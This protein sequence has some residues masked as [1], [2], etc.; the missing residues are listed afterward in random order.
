MRQQG[1]QSPV[2]THGFN[3]ETGNANSFFGLFG[4]DFRVFMKRKVKDD[5]RLDDSV[6]AFLELGRETKSSRAWGFCAFTLEK[7]TEE[8]HALYGRALHFVEAV[9]GAL[10]E[11]NTDRAGVDRSWTTRPRR[12][13]LHVVSF[14]REQGRPTPRGDEGQPEG[15]LD[16]GR[17]QAPRTGTQPEVSPAWHESCR[18]HE[19]A[20]TA[21]DGSHAQADQAVL[22]QTG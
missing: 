21:P 3:G 18:A 17:R 14:T 22:H 8:I 4:N 12:S 5:D 9:P 20:W 15:G 16:G 19:R 10:R 13:I 7:T 11:F 6:R 1:G 2:T